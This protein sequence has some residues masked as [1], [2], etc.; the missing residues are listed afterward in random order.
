VAGLD[1]DPGMLAVAS[2]HNPYILWREGRAEALPFPNAS[3]DAV[4]SQFGLMFFAD[5]HQAIR[6]ML[7]VLK[8]GGRLAVAVWD[9]LE[10]A[11]AYVAPVALLDRLAGAEAADALRAPFACG[12]REALAA[13]FARAGTRDVKIATHRGM[14]RFPGAAAM[15]EAEL[16]GWLPVMGVEL[17]EEQV[18]PI[19][20]EAEQVLQPYL[21]AERRIVFDL[22]A[23]IVTGRAA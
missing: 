3:F 10:N 8:P 14:A 1:Q 19:L 7:R 18:R 20:D 6:E 21:T 12:N 15:V 11:P 16:R 5:R 17:P 22:H 9:S 13:V 4:V 23:H 2:R